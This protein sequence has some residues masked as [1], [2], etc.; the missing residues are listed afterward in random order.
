MKKIL[1]ALILTA[2]IAGGLMVFAP[3]Q[4]QEGVLEN[5]TI[6]VSAAQL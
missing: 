2:F 5:C 6:T 3:V 4:A 1:S